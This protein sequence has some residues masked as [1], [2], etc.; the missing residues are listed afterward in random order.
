MPL[1][2]VVP[3]PQPLFST[4]A[5]TCESLELTTKRTEKVRILAFLKCLRNDEIIPAVTFVTGHAFP[6]PISEFSTLKVIRCGM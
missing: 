4:F 5:T 2:D 6:E 1:E 3:M